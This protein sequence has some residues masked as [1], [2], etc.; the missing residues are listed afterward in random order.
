MVPKYIKFPDN[1]EFIKIAQEFEKR[2]RYPQGVGAIDGSHIRVKIPRDL[3]TAY[4][5]YKDDYSILLLAICDANY[6][7][8]YIK[9]GMPG[10]AHDS[11]AFK[12]TELYAKLNANE[13]LPQ[14]NRII[15]NVLIPYHI[16]GDAA[17]ELKTW[18]MKPY[19]FRDEQTKDE[20]IF[21]YRHS[22]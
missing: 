22:A 2:W 10:R 18:L 16:L 5:N 4:Y 7:F 11:G 12:S 20:T 14:S 17:F 13:L 6:K 8:Y 1:A 21:N 15:N 3:K 9:C 19:T